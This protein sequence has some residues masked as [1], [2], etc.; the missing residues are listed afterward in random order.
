M[1][2]IIIILSESII[3][4]FRARWSLKT[5]HS[6][7]HIWSIWTACTLQEKLVISMCTMI[8][9]RFL[10]SITLTVS[11]NGVRSMRHRKHLLRNAFLPNDRSRWGTRLLHHICIDFWIR[12]TKHLIPEMRKASRR[13]IAIIAMW[14][15]QQNF[16]I[17]CAMQIHLV[18]TSGILMR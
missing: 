7:L 13:N 9:L 16:S 18:R 12:S 17:V 6:V 3:F 4:G 15:A 8:G 1:F 10:V 2:C 5:C 11:E 14:Y